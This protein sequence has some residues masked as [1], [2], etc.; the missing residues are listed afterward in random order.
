MHALR[1]IDTMENWD[2]KK[3]NEVVLS[4]HGNPRATTTIVCKYFLKAIEEKKYGWFWVC[5]NGLSMRWCSGTC[6]L[7]LTQTALAFATPGDNCK[8]RHALPP[9]FVLK[10]EKTKKEDNKEISLA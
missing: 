7:E 8:Y 2:E 4:K 3:L 6:H 1:W 5:P 9:G 10:T